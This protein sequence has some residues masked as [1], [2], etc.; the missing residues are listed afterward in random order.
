[1]RMPV[2]RGKGPCGRPQAGTF[3]KLFKHVLQTL[4]MGDAKYKYCILLFILY[5]LCNRV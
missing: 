5:D 1:M 2:D 3:T 4:S